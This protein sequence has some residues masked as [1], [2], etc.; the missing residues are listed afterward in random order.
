MLELSQFFLTLGAVLLAGFV[1]VA[2]AL[3]L[4]GIAAAT[5]PVATADVAR[6]SGA[7]GHFSDTLLGVV[8][9]DDA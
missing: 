5:D 8:A 2:I 3:V 7:R 4:G 1:A 6:S 9:I